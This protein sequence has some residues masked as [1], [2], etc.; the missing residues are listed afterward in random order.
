MSRDDDGIPG[1]RPGTRRMSTSG[2]IRQG[3]GRWLCVA[4]VGFLT[5]GLTAGDSAPRQGGSET[6]L[7]EFVGGIADQP[8]DI[9]IRGSNSANYTITFDHSMSR[10]RNRTGWWKKLGS[11]R[12]QARPG[13]TLTSTARLDFK[14]SANRRYRLYFSRSNSSDVT[15]Y[16]PSSTS[17][18][19]QTQLNLGD[20]SRYFAASRNTS[21]CAAP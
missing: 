3:A 17:Y 2:R 7:A 19:T 21:S 13:G 15:C 8:C 1:R 9:T 18:T 11:W 5:L 4:G 14:C 6:V 20:I 12:G 10:V 16:Y